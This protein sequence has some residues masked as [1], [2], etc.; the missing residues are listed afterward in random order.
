MRHNQIDLVYKTSA[1]I[2]ASLSLVI[3]CISVKIFVIDEPKQ[4]Q[5]YNKVPKNVD[6]LLQKA[7]DNFLI[8]KVGIIHIGAR[9]AEELPIY[10]NHDINNILWIEADPT[11][12]PLLKANLANDPGSKFAIF[13]AT[14]SNGYIEFNRTSNHGH[15]SSIFKLKNHLLMSPDVIPERTMTVPQQRLDD[16][17][18]INNNLNA[19]SYNMI[20]IDVQGAELLALKGAANTLRNIDA[21]IA[22]VNYDD[23]YEGAVRINDLDIFLIGHG[24]SRV[25]SISVNRG[26]GDALYIKTSFF[27]HKT[28]I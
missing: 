12:E 21:I 5:I 24:F 8:P 11:A 26:Y 15:S 22:E 14:N 3:C 2:F 23:L 28:A 13:A 17:L 19:L 20:V 1:L 16:Y 6:I 4:K 18:N 27:E 10:K 25:D 7:F 9:Y